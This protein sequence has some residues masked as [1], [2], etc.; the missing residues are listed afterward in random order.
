LGSKLG[1]HL[2]EAN[3]CVVATDCMVLEKA[4]CLQWPSLSNPM[5]PPNCL[6]LKIQ[7]QSRLNPDDNSAPA[8]EIQNRTTAVVRRG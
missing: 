6:R 4:V 2:L 3:R 8:M 7:I 1:H 5:N